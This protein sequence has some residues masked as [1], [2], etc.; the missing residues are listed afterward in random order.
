MSRPFEVHLPL[1]RAYT[2]YAMLAVELLDAVTLERVTQGVTIT[3]KGLMG[4]PII[5]HGGLFVWLKEDAGNFEKLL[6]DPRMLPY[7]SAEVPVAQVQR[8]LHVVELSP[9][10]NYPFSPGITAIRGSLVLSVPPPGLAP[11]AIVGAAIRL[12]W[13]DDDG[14]TWHA[15]ATTT[16]TN[17]SGDFTT[18]LRLAPADVPR[19]DSQGQTT[20]KLYAKRSTGEEKHKE[21]QLKQGRVADKTFAWDQMQP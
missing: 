2:R 1:E 14:V 13:L 7:Q 18:I 6:I 11:V 5:N 10:A 15:G 16:A 8:P 4:K 12:E 20:V 17:G 21:F 3:A 9:L 19:L